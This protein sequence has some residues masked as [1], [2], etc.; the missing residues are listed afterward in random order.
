MP[1]TNDAAFTAA[2][3]TGTAAPA[4]SVSPT[5]GAAATA[6]LNWLAPAAP[7]VQANAAWPWASVTIAPGVTL[8]PAEAV[9]TI[10]A[11]GYGRVLSAVTPPPMGLA[12]GPAGFR[13]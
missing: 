5:P 9:P 8:P 1:L 7:T 13:I 2:A 10:R 3:T 4:L 12:D 6:R 11:P